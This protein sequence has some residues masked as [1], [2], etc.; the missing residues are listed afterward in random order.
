MTLTVT[1]NVTKLNLSLVY[2]GISVELKPV[3]VM[4]GSCDCDVI[5]GGTP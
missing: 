4:G 2:D 3:I 5:N 1:Q